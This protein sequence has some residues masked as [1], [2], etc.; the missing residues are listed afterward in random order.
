MLLY[1][2]QN[3]ASQ[4]VDE[5]NEVYFQRDAMIRQAER[6]FIATDGWQ[7]W[8]MQVRHIYLWE[9]KWLTLRWLLWYLFLIKTNYVMTFCVGR[10]NYDDQAYRHWLMQ[11]STVGSFIS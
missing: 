8:L 3:F 6:F 10:A 1:L 4:Y 7:H 11:N 9:D 5:E 2:T